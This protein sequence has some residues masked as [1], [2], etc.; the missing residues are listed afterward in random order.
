MGRRGTDKSLAS[1]VGGGSYVID[2]HAV[3]E[4]MLAR[5]IRGE[6]PRSAMLVASETLDG[7]AAGT[8]EGS[9]ASGSSLA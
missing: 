1:R 8:A 3:A 6:L 2:E 7:L 5:L 4:A 9:P